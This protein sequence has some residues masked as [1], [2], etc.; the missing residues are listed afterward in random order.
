MFFKER[1]PCLV[2]LGTGW[3]WKWD[4]K[5]VLERG[6]H[7]CMGS[8][9][10]IEKTRKAASHQWNRQIIHTRVQHSRW[11]IIIKRMLGTRAYQILK[12]STKQIEKGLCFCQEEKVV[13]QKQ[14]IWAASMLLIVSDICLALEGHFMHPSVPYIRLSW[15]RQIA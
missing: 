15:A 13:I 1:P 7:L 10:S 3:L 6:Y 9:H 4:S 12:L 2:I 14:Q 11:K 8:H 5:R